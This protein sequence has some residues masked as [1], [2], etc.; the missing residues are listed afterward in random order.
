[1]LIQCWD[2]FGNPSHNLGGGNIK[3]ILNGSLLMAL[4]VDDTTGTGE[5]AKVYTTTLARE[6]ALLSVLWSDGNAHLGASPLVVD[7]HPN[8]PVAENTAVVRID[9]NGDTV[10]PNS[11]WVESA[12]QLTGPSPAAA[13]DLAQG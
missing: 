5:F 6:D 7:V 11:P 4:T 10:S 3:L 2:Q 13:F 9:S 1:M 8:Y 12:V